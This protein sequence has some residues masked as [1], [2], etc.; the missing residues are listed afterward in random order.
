MKGEGKARSKGQTYGHTWQ[1]KRLYQLGRFPLCADPFGLHGKI[2]VGADEVDHIIPLSRGG[3]DVESNYQSLCKS[4]HSRKTA[5][6]QRGRLVQY[7]KPKAT[8]T[9]INGPP[10]GGKSHY[11]NGRVVWGDLVIDLDLLFVA[12]S[13]Q[14][15]YDKPNSLYPF[16]F[17]MYDALLHRLGSVSEV[18]T[19]WLI[20][21]D[22]DRVAV[23]KLQ[24]VLHAK[25]IEIIP[26]KNIALQRLRADDRRSHNY[27]QWKELID[28]WYSSRL[29]DGYR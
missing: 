11:A 9:I 21:S 3:A 16:V 6:E 2:V 5:L 4:C 28:K 23:Q 7:P 24:G 1:K 10:C 18:N 15:I 26:N 22:H 25:L 8:V 14:P 27:D 17:A 20:T 19:V 13:G 29:G 12:I